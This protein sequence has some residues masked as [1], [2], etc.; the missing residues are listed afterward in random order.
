MLGKVIR[1]KPAR[2]KEPAT[3]ARSSLADAILQQFLME[4]DAPV[5]PTLVPA[6][7]LPFDHVGKGRALRVISPVQLHLISPFTLAY[8]MGALSEPFRS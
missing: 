3:P 7:I 2:Q 4:A 1:L 5:K 6:Q 8:W